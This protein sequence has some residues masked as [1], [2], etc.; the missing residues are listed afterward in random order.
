MI[1]HVYSYGTPIYVW[2]IMLPHTC[3]GY[4][5]HIWDVPYTYIWANVLIWGRAAKSIHF[6]QSSSYVCNKHR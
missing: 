6:K 1:M 4:P 3:T 5:I 2:D